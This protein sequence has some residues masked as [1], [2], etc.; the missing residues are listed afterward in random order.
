MHFCSS[1]SSSAD[2]LFVCCSRWLPVSAEW[3]YLLWLCCRLFRGLPRILL[4]RSRSKCPLFLSATSFM[5]ITSSQNEVTASL[6][7]SPASSALTI[8][9]GDKF[10]PMV[11][12]S[13]PRCS[14]KALH[15][16]SMCCA[17]STSA[18]QWWQ[19]AVFS[20]PI[21]FRYSPK[22]PCLVPEL[23]YMLQAGPDS[24]H[25]SQLGRMAPVALLSAALL[26][27]SSRVHLDRARRIALC[28]G[29]S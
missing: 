22:H 1:A 15:S 17:E 5:P 3:C 14:S 9:A 26:H 23:S 20:A 8:A 21:L 4:V 24:A 2:A 10:L 19:D 11:A 18:S 25:F 27:S 6:L 29:H 28:F 13:L 7:V 12:V 16:A